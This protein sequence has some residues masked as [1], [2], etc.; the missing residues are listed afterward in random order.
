MAEQQKTNSETGHAGGGHH[1]A[2]PPFD[3]KNYPSQI[4]WFAIAFGILY[5]VMSRVALP[6]VKDIIDSRAGK[7]QQDLDAAHRMREEANEAAKAYEKTLAEA[8]A[9]AQALAQQT[10]AKVK[11]EQDARRQSVESELNDKLQAAELQISEMK[12]GAMSNVSQIASEAASAIVQH[13]TGGEPDSTM[14]AAAVSDVTR[15]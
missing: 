9:N 15:L 4:L 1:E 3:A 7:I 14:V 2:F 10:R 6:R 11:L 13:F 8:K 5:V 12:A